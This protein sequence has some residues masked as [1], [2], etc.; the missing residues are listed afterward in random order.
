M[1]EEIK[2]TL[3]SRGYSC[4]EIKVIEDEYVEAKNEGINDDQLTSL[5]HK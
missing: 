1:D 4:E 2:E 5:L 3:K